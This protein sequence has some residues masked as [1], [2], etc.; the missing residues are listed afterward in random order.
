MSQED[1]MQDLQIARSA[2]AVGAL[3][4]AVHGEQYLSELLNHGKSQAT[5]KTYRDR[6][7]WFGEWL[8]SLGC[9]LAAVSRGLVE[10]WMSDMR[11]RG[12][13]PAT[14]KE[15]VGAVRGFFVWLADVELIPKNPLVRLRPVKIPKKLPKVMQPAAVESII[16]AA[17]TPLERAVLE[18]LYGAGLRNAEVRG[19]QLEDL[20]LAAPRII[21]RGKGDKERLVP[22]GAAAATALEA[23]LPQRDAILTAITRPDER[24]LFV[25]KQGAYRSPQSIRDVVS[26]VAKRAG[27]TGRIYPHLFRHSYATHL[28]DGGADL[29]AVQEL[30]GHESIRTTQGYTHVSTERL[31][32]AV[33]AAHPRAET[34]GAALPR[35]TSRCAN[36]ECRRGPGGTPVEIPTAMALVGRRY[37]CR[38]CRPSEHKRTVE[39]PCANE[40]CSTGP[41]GTRGSLQVR[42]GNTRWLYCRRECQPGQQSLSRREARPTEPRWSAEAAP[43]EQGP[44]QDRSCAYEHCSRGSDGRRAIVQS[45]NVRAIYCSWPCK[46]AASRRRRDLEHSSITR[47]CA[48]ETCTSGPGGARASLNLTAMSRIR[49]CATCGPVMRRRVPKTREDRPCSNERCRRG[50]GGARAIVRHVPVDERR[51][52]YCTVAC[53]VMFRYYQAKGGSGA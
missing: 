11:T 9:G 34:L 37:C 8:R 47:P 33:A 13:A 23:W 42:P 29:R 3:S 22:L 26:R 5:A 41:G 28:L 35:L 21:I 18:L 30:L 51:P 10:Q 1:R 48:N 40:L 45:A 15:N 12:L 27:F 2:G 49:F 25:S 7:R 14:I 50:P 44:R 39:R 53:G 16:N 32:A 38:N 43:P 52:R 31:R 4:I 36:P 6:L 19:L 20:D 24:A 46:L 17:R